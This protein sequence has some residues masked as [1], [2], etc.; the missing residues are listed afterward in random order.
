LPSFLLFNLRIKNHSC[1][2]EEAFNE[3][4]LGRRGSSIK[5][6]KGQL[7]SKAMDERGKALEEEYFRR[8]ERE[9]IE[10][11]RAKMSAEEQEKAKAASALRCPKC[12]GTL[13]GVIHDQVEIDV[14]NTCGGAWLDAGELEQLAKR[15]TGGWL[16]K[17]WGKDE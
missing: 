13:E 17:L 4:R 11:L 14:C 9:A 6:M 5:T 8:K 3:K 10:K 15:E 16:S 2:S 12:D 7:M 1:A